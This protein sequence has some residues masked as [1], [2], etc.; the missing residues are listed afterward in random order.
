LRKNGNY[1]CNKLERIWEGKGSIT[2]INWREFGKEREVPLQLSGENLGRK[3]KHCH[4]KLERI[5]E[6]KESSI[7]KITFSTIALTVSENSRGERDTGQT[8]SLP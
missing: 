7:I 5:W 2:I 6:G 1:Y 4:N 8:M 3:G